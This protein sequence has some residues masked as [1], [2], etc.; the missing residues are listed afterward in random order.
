MKAKLNY[1]YKHPGRTAI[2]VSTMDREGIGKILRNPMCAH[3]S[4]F[5]LIPSL[6]RLQHIE[7]RRVDL[8]SIE[9]MSDWGNASA[10]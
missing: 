1:E 9:L 2:A 8:P 7:P 6:Q 4:V 10:F 5:A 3:T